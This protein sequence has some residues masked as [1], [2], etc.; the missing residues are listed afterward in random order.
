MNLLRERGLHVLHHAIVVGLAKQIRQEEARDVNALIGVG[1][2]IICRNT[3][4]NRPEHL[5]NHV[6]EEAGLL[7]F[8]FVS[9]DVGKELLGENVLH[10]ALLLGF[11][12]P[13][14][15]IFS[16]PCQCLVAG[17]DGTGLH[18][19][20]DH[21]R[22]IGILILFSQDQLIDITIRKDTES[23]KED[24]NGDLCF[25]ARDRCANHGNELIFWVIDHFDG[26]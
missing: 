15:G 18:H 6:S 20:L 16:Q 26:V 5:A 13:G 10:I 4:A 24:D 12:R 3:L 19:T 9:T 25:D 8:H 11:D 22:I 7:V 14:I 2:T 21:N 17:I 23:A 1:I